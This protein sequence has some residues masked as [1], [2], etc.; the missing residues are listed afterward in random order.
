MLVNREQLLQTLESIQPGLNP[1]DVIEQSACFVFRGKRVYTFNDE[2]ACA[3]R[4]MLGV[5]GAVPAEPLLNLLRKLPEEELDIAAG[6]GLLVVKGK[7][8]GADIP[9]E[10]EIQ[11]PID[12][13]E[14]PTE[15]T[16]LPTDF[17]DAIGHAQIC[18]GKDGTK[19]AFVH[20]HPKWIESCDSM[21]L[22]RYRIATGLREPV[23]VRGSSVKHVVALGV[24]EFCETDSWLHFRNANRTIFSCRRYLD[25]Y[26]NLGK[27]LDVTGDPWTIPKGLAE[28]CDKAQI[29]SAANADPT[30]NVVNIQLTPGKVRIRSTGAMGRY[31]ES[32]KLAYTGKPVNFVIS[33]KML[34]DIVGRHSE[35][36][37]TEE[38]LKVDGGKWKY[39]GCLAA[40]DADDGVEVETST[41]G[42]DQHG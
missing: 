24:T 12:S 34:M 36:I 17:T 11:L 37:I 15:W 20:I 13:V 3:A 41:T 18:V 16:P 25:D 4:S 8:R 30:N 32:K 21:Q 39:I 10:A 33:P 42:D 35:C 7:R 2:I 40:A 27:L 29:F 26:M 5:T 38:R 14:A 31:W 19:Y 6:E 23:L 22:I 9:M 28:A 1:R